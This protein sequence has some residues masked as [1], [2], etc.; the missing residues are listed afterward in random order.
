M[1]RWKLATAHYL[2][3]P[4]TE[5]AYMEVSRTTR[6]QERRVFTVP[7]LIDPQ[8]PISWTNR[9]GTKDDEEGECIVCHEGKGERTDIVFTGDPTPDMIPLDEEAEKLSASFAAKWKVSH[10]TTLGAHSQSIISTLEERV[11]EAASRPTATTVDGLDT[12]ISTVSELVKQ[13]AILIQHLAKPP[14]MVNDPIDGIR[15]L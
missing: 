5:W 1:A 13:N 4:G 14:A 6:R 15:R 3:S 8:D 7:L 10:A 2:N 9:W 12:F 11:G